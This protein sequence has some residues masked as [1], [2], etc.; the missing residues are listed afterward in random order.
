[1]REGGVDKEERNKVNNKCVSSPRGFEAM[2]RSVVLGFRGGR[3]WLIGVPSFGMILMGRAGRVGEDG[4][5]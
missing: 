1:M 3:G 5:G 4:G 2:V